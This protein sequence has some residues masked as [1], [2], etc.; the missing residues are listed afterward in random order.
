MKRDCLAGYRLSGTR[1]RVAHVNVWRETPALIVKDIR[2]MYSVD[3]LATLGSAQTLD[4]L[5]TTNL[6]TR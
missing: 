6:G 4:I 1:Q 2:Y 5:F 3:S